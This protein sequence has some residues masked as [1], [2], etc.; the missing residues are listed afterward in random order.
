MDEREEFSV[1]SAPFSG[2]PGIS[3][4]AHGA[5]EA[6]RVLR[7]APRLQIAL[8]VE[9]D[10]VV[11]EGRPHFKPAVVRAGRPHFKPAAA[12]TRASGTA[13]SVAARSGMAE[14]ERF[15]R[16]AKRGLGV[17]RLKIG[18]FARR[19]KGAPESLEARPG[20]QWVLGS[21]ARSPE[22]MVATG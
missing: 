14:S 18:D 4:G 13:A 20:T 5:S 15:M 9:S 17:E 2:P 22:P 12:R 16:Y 10:A 1:L 8:G 6:L 7:R 19:Q 3:G 11:R 21:V